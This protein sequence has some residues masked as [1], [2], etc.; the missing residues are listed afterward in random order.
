MRPLTPGGW[1]AGAFVLLPRAALAD[2]AIHS[3]AKIALAYAVTLAT[4][5]RTARGAPVK[6]HAVRTRTERTALCRTALAA[7]FRE[8]ADA[9]YLTLQTD[10]AARHKGTLVVLDAKALAGP[11]A[12]LE[13]ATLALNRDPLLRLALAESEGFCA[14]LIREGTTTRPLDYR[15]QTLWGAA[16]GARRQT[17]CAVQ[18]E[19]EAIGALELVAHHRKSVIR[20]HTQP[21]D[22]RLAL[23]PLPGRLG[24]GAAPAK[25]VRA[26]RRAR[27][28]AAAPA[29]TN[30]P[31]KRTRTSRKAGQESAQIADTI[32]PFRS[33]PLREKIGPSTPCTQ[34]V[35][36]SATPYAMRQAR[37]DSERVANVE[38]IALRSMAKALFGARE[39]DAFQADATWSTLSPDQQRATTRRMR[40]TPDLQRRRELLLPPLPIADVLPSLVG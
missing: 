9:G 15:T 24:H 2:R 33:P 36:E 29:D 22:T 11:H 25:P 4:Q 1:R 3:S 17:M 10:R 7:A 27:I 16:I 6:L 26:R 20:A 39:W 32:L 28:S 14:S 30:Q 40:D 8:L 38:A 12:R 34:D 23:L 18:R 13:W 31:K 21:A 35:P 5:T 37:T 19:L